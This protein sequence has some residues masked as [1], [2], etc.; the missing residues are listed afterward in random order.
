MQETAV[1]S[2]YCGD[3]DACA[4]VMRNAIAINGSVLNA[5]PM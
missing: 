2:L 4:V 3:Q 5:Q 1:Q